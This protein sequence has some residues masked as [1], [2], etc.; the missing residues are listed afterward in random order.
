MRCGGGLRLEYSNPMHL[1]DV[2]IDFPDMQI[3]MAHPS[4]PCH[5]LLQLLPAFLHH[6]DQ[7]GRSL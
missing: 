2:A 1:D 5:L 6:R 7:L 3:V 4:F